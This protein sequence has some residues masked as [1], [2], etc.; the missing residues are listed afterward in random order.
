MELVRGS[1]AVDTEMVM[2][3]YVTL[4]RLQMALAEHKQALTTLD[5][6]TRLGQER[7]FVPI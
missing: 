2:L 4:A 6:L 5:T 3:G 7:S 1:L